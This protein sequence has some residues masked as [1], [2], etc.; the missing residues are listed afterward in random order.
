[1]WVQ[2]PSPQ[3]HF[4]MTDTDAAYL[5]G[6][7]DGEGSVSFGWVKASKN[8]KRYGKL[9]AKISQNDRRVL[10]WVQAVTG[11]G[12]VHARHRVG[13]NLAHDFVVGHESARFFLSIVRPYLKIKGETV[14]E[15]LALDAANCRRQKRFTVP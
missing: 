5:A 9:F 10:D 11:V 4:V 15:K 14:D 6:L 7:F 3:Y 8:G 12:S 2:L 1:M 13:R